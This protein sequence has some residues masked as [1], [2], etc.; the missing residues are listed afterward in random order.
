VGKKALT[1]SQKL[2]NREQ[3]EELNYGKNR[4]VLRFNSIEKAQLNL[5]EDGFRYKESYSFKEDRALLY[6]HKRYNA[7]VKLYS[8]FDYLDD[9]TTDMG[10][11]WL[12]EDVK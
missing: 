2:K 11:V 6:K 5:R 1:H 4:I 8:T 9:N 3:Y 7:W 10:T 12:I